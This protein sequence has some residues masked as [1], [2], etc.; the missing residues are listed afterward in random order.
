MTNSETGFITIGQVFGPWGIK[1]KIRV[2]VMTDFP[3]H[4]NPGETVYI[5][6]KSFTVEETDWSKSNALIK[7]KGVDCVNDAEEFVGKYVEISPIQLHPLSA[8]QY[9]HFQIAG[10]KVVTTGGR[11]IG[12]ISDIL[13][14]AANDIYIVK[15]KDGEILIPATADVIKSID[16]DKKV[17]TIEAVPGL[18]ELNKKTT[19]DK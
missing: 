17:M 16:L 18:L 13:T 19:G 12:V 15:G 4:F 7:I 8:G 1:G 10:L 11:E 14:S 9:Y 3:E 2:N 5:D 6:G